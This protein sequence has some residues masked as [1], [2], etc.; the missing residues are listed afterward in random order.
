MRR[1]RLIINL[2]TR[3]VIWRFRVI[4]YLKRVP[5]F[6]DF[7]SSYILNT[8]PDFTI[9]AHR[10]KPELDF[11]TTR[12]MGLGNFQRAPLFLQCYPQGLLLARLRVRASGFRGHEHIG[13]E[14]Q[15]P[16]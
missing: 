1:F 4:I 6:R 3:H 7:G 2:E 11:D 15:E 9:P 5:S 8:S 14:L 13:H 10:A 16:A 12:K